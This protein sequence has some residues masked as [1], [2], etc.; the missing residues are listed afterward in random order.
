MGKYL[1]RGIYLDICEHIHFIFTVNSKY[2]RYLL[3][4][5]IS[6]QLKGVGLQL[7]HL[8]IF[9]KNFRKM[10]GNV[11]TTFEQYLEIFAYLW[12][13]AENLRKISQNFVIT[14]LRG[15]VG[16][17]QFKKKCRWRVK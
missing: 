9:L 15:F 6:N 8:P 5:P 1:V 16:F 17:P 11:R 4:L 7:K 3:C 13:S 12:I 14:L 2:L 10:I